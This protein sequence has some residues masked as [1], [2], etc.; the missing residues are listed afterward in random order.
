MITKAK[1]KAKVKDDKKP[2]LNKK[3]VLFN[4]YGIG[5]KPQHYRGK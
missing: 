2:A 4:R 1:N 5:K 3:E